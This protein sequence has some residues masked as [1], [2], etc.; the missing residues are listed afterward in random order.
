MSICPT[1]SRTF[2]ASD[3]TLKKSAKK[4]KIVNNDNKNNSKQPV[5][6]GLGEFLSPFLNKNWRISGLKDKNVVRAL[7]KGDAEYVEIEFNFIY[8]NLYENVPDFIAVDFV[9]Y[10][11]CSKNL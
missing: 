6:K 9:Y 4:Q 2:G 1:I 8:N 7:S 10:S 5:F 3:S 11:Q